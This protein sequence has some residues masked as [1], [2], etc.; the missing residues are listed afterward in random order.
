LSEN[1]N[2]I[3]ALTSK[4]AEPIFPLT[5]APISALLVVIASLHAALKKEARFK[6]NC[7]SKPKPF[8][9]MYS[10]AAEPTHICVNTLTPLHLK[11]SLA[12]GGITCERH[13]S[14][15]AAA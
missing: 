9:L 10:P 15:L 7:A 13:R 1:V 14:K 8:V 12:S 11:K 4:L 3:V 2:P 6:S 5:V